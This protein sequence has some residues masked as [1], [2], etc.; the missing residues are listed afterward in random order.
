MT[1]ALQAAMTHHPP[2]FYDDDEMYT[3][4]SSNSDDDVK[5]TNI[6]NID[7][8]SSS[9]VNHND[10]GSDSDSDSDVKENVNNNVNHQDS[11]RNS[12]VN[13]NG[14]NTTN[15]KNNFVNMEEESSSLPL[16][17][18]NEIDVYGKWSS[19]EKLSVL[20]KLVNFQIRERHEQVL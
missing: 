15:G 10:D 3:T 13:Y 11:D 1:V 14:N 4:I 12:D 16:N 8:L 6:L 17:T 19:L 5:V 9:D 18:K 2:D 7:Y 20:S